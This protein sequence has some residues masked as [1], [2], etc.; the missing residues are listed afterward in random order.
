M[1][2][3]V[4]KEQYLFFRTTRRDLFQPGRMPVFTEFGS[5]LDDDIGMYGFPMLELDAVKV[6]AHQRG[7]TTTA[8]TRTFEIES[9]GAEA[10]KEYAKRRF[11]NVLGEIVE[12]KTCLY[13]NTPDRHFILD[14]APRQPNM[15]I[16]SACSGHGF[17]F[18]ILIGKIAADL[19]MSGKT[20]YPIE[21]FSIKRLVAK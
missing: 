1:P 12:A 4:R 5:G 13:T 17:K 3:Q 15:V 21:M 16:A 14:I 2:L 19:A 10:V 9:E 11:G 8:S 7:P 6:A 20:E 18:A